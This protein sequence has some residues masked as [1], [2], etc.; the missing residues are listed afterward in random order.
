MKTLAFI[1]F[2]VFVSLLHAQ[3]T[4]FL[5]A[6]DSSIEDVLLV[7]NE[8]ADMHFY[9]GE[10]LT[11]LENYQK[12]ICYLKSNGLSDP[13]NLLQALC[14]S[15]FCYDLLNQYEFAKAAFDEL[16]YEVA[17]L[18][19]KIEE[20]DWFRHSLIYPKF[21][22]NSNRY[23]VRIEK[24]GLPEM[25][26]EESCQLQCNGYAVAA[27]FAC[28]KVPNLAVQFICYGCIFGLE[29]VCVRCCKGKGFWENCVK[30]LRRLFHDPQ[31]PEN[32]APHPYE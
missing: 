12:V 17:L 26:P 15:M 20:I 8:K 5:Q 18:N 22:Q 30:G 29:Q 2:T 6:V 28:G 1:I 9:R 32:P 23:D 13:S 16:V 4:E 25:T 10:Y 19:E 7:Y 21:I 31:H 24:I 3:Q 14:G 27:G 11:S